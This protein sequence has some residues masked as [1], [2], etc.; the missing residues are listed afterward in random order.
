V[1][2]GDIAWVSIQAIPARIEKYVVKGAFRTEKWVTIRCS[3]G[4]SAKK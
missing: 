4:T 1:A 2:K 3:A